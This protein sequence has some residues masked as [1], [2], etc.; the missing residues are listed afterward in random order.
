MTRTFKLKSYRVIQ[1]GGF[2]ICRRWIPAWCKNND[3]I[4]LNDDVIKP[5]SDKGF[6]EN[7]KGMETIHTLFFTFK[8]RNKKR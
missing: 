7:Q 1:F 6:V 3:M 8:K 2:W 5:E 4:F